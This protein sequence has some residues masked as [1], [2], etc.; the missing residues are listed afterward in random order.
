MTVP[1]STAKNTYTGNGSLTTYSYTFKI[2]DDDDI[3]VLVDDVVQTKTSDYTVTGVD[4]DAGGTVVFT[5]APSNGASIVLLRSMT[6]EQTFDYTENGVFPAESHEAALDKL[7]M[8]AQQLKEEITRTIKF[9]ED[10][11]DSTDTTFPS[12]TGN[13]DKVLTVDTDELGVSWASLGDASTITLPVSVANGGTGSTAGELTLSQGANREIKVAEETTGAG[14]DLTVSAGDAE[15]LANDTAGGNLVL[16]SGA[17]EGTGTSQVTVRAAKAGSS[18]ST[19]NTPQDALVVKAEGAELEPHGTS[20]G[21]TGELRL[22]EL[23]ASGSNYVGFKAP[24]SIASNAIFTMPS[25]YPGSTQ[26]LQS[27]SS[28]NLSFTASAGG[29]APTG[30]I[31]G[32]LMSNAAD[33]SHDITISAGLARDFA[34]TQDM[35]LAS[36]IT[37]QIDVNWAEGT[38]SGGFPSGLTLTANTWYRV[39]I[40]RKTSDGTID[41]GFDTSATASNLLADATGYSQYRRVGWVWTNG[42]ANIFGF[43]MLDGKVLFNFG[44]NDESATSIG[45]TLSSAMTATVPPNHIGILNIMGQNSNNF[46]MIVQPADLGD[47]GTVSSDWHTVSAFHSTTGTGNTQA[48]IRVDSNSQVKAKASAASTLLYMTSWGFVDTREI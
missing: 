38:A 10:V 45:T 12:L 32:L 9:S 46:A 18:G 43:Q 23:A 35:V 36:A 29:S 17:S 2:F 30:Y 44:W 4:A 47:P 8:M 20:S 21:N 14:S 27:D 15:A 42:S 13:Q 1:S 33:A 16:E 22:K 48:L 6:F 26:V 37:K 19:T 39:F 31:S 3:Q 5:T 41:A 25:A 34:D 24:D 40:I 28:G 11:S 7:V